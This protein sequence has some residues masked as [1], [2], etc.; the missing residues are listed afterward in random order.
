M[1][2]LMIL[3][4]SIHSIIFVNAQDDTVRVDNFKELG[5]YFTQNFKVNYPYLTY[6]R[7]N[8]I[9]PTANIFD[10]YQ[11][12]MDDPTINVIQYLGLVNSLSLANY[13]VDDKINLKYL[14]NKLVD[15]L[16]QGLYPISISLI[17][18]YKFKDSTVALGYIGFENNRYVDYS[19]LDFDIFEKDT[20]FSS[21]VLNQVFDSESIVF[22]FDESL[23]LSNIPFEDVNSIEVDFDNGKG[24]VPIQDYHTINYLKDDFYRINVKL[25]INSKTFYSSFGITVNRNETIA[26]DNCASDAP[27]DFPN[28]GPKAISTISETNELI[29][30]E[31]AVW[32]SHCNNTGKIRKPFII[33]AGYNP[34]NGK[35]FLPGIIAPFL[36]QFEGE[37]IAIPLLGGWNGEF[38]GTFYETYNGSY[39]QRFSPEEYCFFGNRAK[40]ENQFLDRLRDEGYD[41]IIL[42][43]DNGTAVTKDN[44]TLFMKLIEI[45]N[46][47]KF[48]NGY[49]HENV[50]CGYSA[51]AITTKVAL[52]KMEARYKQN[53]G[54][55][56]HSKLW[57]SFDGE[58][59]GANV[60]LGLQ[61]FF[62]FYSDGY[63]T[64]PSL[65]PVTLLADLIG[66]GISTLSYN[67]IDTD[68]ANEILILNAAANNGVHQKRLEMLDMISSIPNNSSNGNPEFTRR[69]GV[70]Q[71]S[72]T[73]VKIPHNSPV[74]IETQLGTD[75]SGTA[76]S[77]SNTCG[78]SYTWVAPKC[79]KRATAR[80]IS[81][82]N[83][84]NVFD[85][86]VILDASFTILPMICVNLPWIGC[87]C[88]QPVTVNIP[89]QIKNRNI[90]RPVGSNNIDDM[91]AS[92]SFP[93]IE[94]YELW[95]KRH[96][97]WSAGL[98]A[99]ANRDTRFCSFTPTASALDLHDPTNGYEANLN[100]SPLGL[101]LLYK[102]LIISGSLSAEDNRR[103]GFPHL[104]YPTNHYQITPFDGIC[105]VGDNNGTFMN[106][107]QRPPNQ[108]HVEDAQKFI[109]DY[110]ARIEVA[111]E[112]LFLTNHSVGASAKLSAQYMGGYK[113]EYEARERI[114]IGSQQ[115]NGESIYNL[116]GNLNHL[117]PTGV[118]KVENDA[119]AIFRTPEIELHDGVEMDFGANAEFIPEAYNCDNLL[120]INVNPDVHQ[121]AI[122]NKEGVAFTF[123]VTTDL[124][125]VYN[126]PNPVGKTTGFQLYPNPSSDL[127][128]IVNHSESENSAYK[129]LS[130]SGQE[131]LTGTI[132]N[133]RDETLS[134]GYLPNGVYFLMV[135][136]NGVLFTERIVLYK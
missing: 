8:L 119:Y 94:V 25:I 103:Y 19:P 30:G 9:S 53:L 45:V 85:G 79:I 14:Q 115:I 35:K 71:G 29:S 74:I 105:A 17:E 112:I 118:F 62:K 18:N 39:N 97:T 5:H 52:A 110:L 78:G 100:L 56:H 58:H 108:L 46:A 93:H 130:V 63:Y 128:T 20:L 106:G 68:N 76:V 15:N 40:N 37:T 43:Y 96:N 3:I 67:A 77:I 7:Y 109:G 107:T 38:R 98:N 135:N 72:G 59:Q 122:H 64:I 80:H 75:L 4:L 23:F 101:D 84:A 111:P 65:N 24:Y 133:N 61:H 73:G 11:G 51:G 121:R 28:V 21:C 87:Q 113:A 66:N 32:F 48:A 123:K 31:Y 89:I 124:V 1:K 88:I 102:G 127:I 12:Q 116:Y 42:G 117:S 126:N 60:P 92:T 2:K 82:N 57:I 36:F 131:L 125:Q 49:Y 16:T 50:I 120:F 22:T 6:C 26:K 134:I 13:D 55:H 86:T 83:S 81:S 90:A 91:S 47:E 129:I 33:S 99:F 27:V 69:V 44:A 104:K 41:V 132:R 54:P 114:I 70:S 95:F 34:S 10:L 136:N